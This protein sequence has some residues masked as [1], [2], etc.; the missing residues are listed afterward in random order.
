MR[1]LNKLSGGELQRV[2]VAEALGKKAD[3]IL[4]DE[5]SAYLDTEQRLNISKIIRNVADTTGKAILVVDHDLVF[6]DYVANRLIVFEGTPAKEGTQIGPVAME[7][8]MNLLLKEVEIT[9]RRDEQS[10]RPRIN[11]LDSV[12]DRK[13]KEKGNYYYS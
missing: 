7:E 6:L 9:L 8:G 13:Q 10:G 11:K 12:M 4:L 2:A 5:P 1:P 3:I